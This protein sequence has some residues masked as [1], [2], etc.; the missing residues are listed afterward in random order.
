MARVPDWR[1]KPEQVWISCQDVR[2]IDPGDEL[3]VQFLA[4]GETYISFVHKRFVHRDKKWLQGY[5]VADWDDDL[6]VDLPAET[7]TSGCRILVRHAEQGV[8]LHSAP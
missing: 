8:V 5:I 1:S 4:N 2:E 3:L 6:L 7:L